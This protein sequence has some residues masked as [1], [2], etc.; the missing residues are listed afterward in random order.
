MPNQKIF[1]R[2]R[3]NRSFFLTKTQRK[4]KKR[5]KIAAVKSHAAP[6]DAPPT[7]YDYSSTRFSS[8][9]PSRSLLQTALPFPQDPPQVKTPI[10]SL[11][12][13]VPSASVPASPPFI[14]ITAVLTHVRESAPVDNSLRGDPADCHHGQPAVLHLAQFV[15]RLLVSVLGQ[16]QRVHSEVTFDEIIHRFGKWR[17][18]GGAHSLIHYELWR[19]KKQNKTKNK[20]T[21][22]MSD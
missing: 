10:H 13:N 6:E 9:L 18:G 15:P 1:V 8:R 7:N 4:G 17:T 19:S 14:K 21:F 20:C 22:I 3:H 12:V 2:G 5:R 11:S 16:V